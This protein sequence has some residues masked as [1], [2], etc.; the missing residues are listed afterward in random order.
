[1]KQAINNIDLMVQSIDTRSE[2]VVK[3]IT[4]CFDDVILLLG[5]KKQLL[6]DETKELQKSKNNKLIG[7]KGKL[8]FALNNIENQTLFTEKKI[9]TAAVIVS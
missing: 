6:I 1:M 2:A 3:E 5:K 7:Q 9:L 4:Q 8:I